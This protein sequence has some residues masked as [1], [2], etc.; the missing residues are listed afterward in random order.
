MYG[1]SF[2]ECPSFKESSRCTFFT[3]QSVCPILYRLMTVASNVPR[4]LSCISRLQTTSVDSV[5]KVS[6]RWPRMHPVSSSPCVPLRNSECM[7]LLYRLFVFALNVSHIFS[8]LSIRQTES[9]DSDLEL[10]L[11]GGLFR[12]SWIES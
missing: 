10:E 5:G 12:W 6:T 1:P 7:P 2:T 11:G 8:C 3:H 4:D 9:V